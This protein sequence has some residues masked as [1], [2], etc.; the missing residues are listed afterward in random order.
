MTA[1]LLRGDVNTEVTIEVARRRST[2]EGED[3]GQNTGIQKTNTDKLERH[4]T[5]DM[6]NI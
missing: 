3:T 1:E 6:T 2:W 5:K 4:H